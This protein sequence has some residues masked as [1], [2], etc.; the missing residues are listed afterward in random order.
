[1]ARIVRNSKLDTR[2]ARSDLPQRKAPY[3][4]AISP[5]FALGYRKAP[6]GGVWLG[7]LATP[8]FRKESKL[9]PADDA[10]DPDGVHILSFAQAQKTA[11]NWKARTEAA[12]DGVK[13]P[14][15]VREALDSYEADL[16]ARSGDAGNVGRLRA[17]LADDLL[18]KAVASLTWSELRK[19]RDGLV[20]A[21]AH[22]KTSRKAVKL[23]PATIN[24]TCTVLKAALNHVAADPDCA[25][26]DAFADRNPALLDKRLLSRHY[27]SSTLAAGPAHRS[28]VEPDLLP[29]P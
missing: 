22:K 7:K 24:R 14:K 27:L 9:G 19:W 8:G 10:L 20:N 4:H 21:Q 12:A 13:K 11:F 6:K 15:T 5:G 1:M 28:W 3:W 25:E 29:F 17:H 23:S 26:F 18:D 16:K 2:S